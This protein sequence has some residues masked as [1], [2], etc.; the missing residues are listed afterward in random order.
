[1]IIIYHDGS[2][3]VELSNPNTST[4]NKINSLPIAQFIF[5]MAKEYPEAILVW[6]HVNLKMQLNTQEIQGLLH[7]KRM[8]LS[9]SPSQ[10]NFFDSKMGYVE[11]SPFIKINKSVTF[12]TWQ[13]SSL[14]GV[15]H[16]KVISAFNNQIPFDKDF[17]YFLCSIAK[18]AMPKGLFCYSEPRL[19]LQNT[20]IE[21]PKANF[22]TLFRFVKQHYKTRWL[23]LLLLNLIL[24]ERKLPLLPFLVSFFYK[25][26]SNKK[27]NLDGI[28]VQ[29]SRHFVD[30]KTIDVI[31]PTIGRKNYLYNVLQDF[32]KQTLLPNKIIIVEQNPVEGSVSELDYLV[33]ETWPFAIEHIF[34]HQAGACNARNLALKEITNEW[35]FFADDDIRIEANFLQKVLEK[36]AN[37]DEKAVSISCLQKGQEQ[38]LKNIFQWGTFGSGCSFVFGEILRGCEFNMGYEFGFGEDGDFGMQLRNKGCDVL[39]LPEPEI[40]HLKAPIGG[41]RTKPVL[42]WQNESIQPKPSPTIM[43]YQILHNTKEQ[44]AGYKTI[45]FF[46]YY[47][48]Q[49]IKNPFRYFSIFQKQ[50]NC[51]VFWANKLNFATIV[52][53]GS[54]ANVISRRNPDC[55]RLY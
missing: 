31:I 8:M 44:I 30:K 54:G 20:P 43:L 48:H 39:Y 16:A 10:D 29:S 24:Y 33:N 52:A 4:V 22:H 18:L 46:K 35:V 6:C 9:Y 51:S 28:A 27:I 50:W 49:K 3:V 38:K 34:I 26:R 41:F 25:K 53:I 40:L 42:Q 1:M 21:I 2:K 11:E 5:E 7:H 47:N 17:D 12:P 23:F 55:R 37:F 36:I 14:V 45:L 19:L 32:S 13:M 15:A